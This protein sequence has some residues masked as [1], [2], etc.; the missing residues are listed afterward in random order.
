MSIPDLRQVGADIMA[1]FCVIKDEQSTSMLLQPVA[2][3]LDLDGLFS[4]LTFR[5]VEFDG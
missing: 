4:G 5:Q 2:Y 1:F 3:R